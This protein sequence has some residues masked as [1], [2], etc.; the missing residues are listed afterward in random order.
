[1]A[2]IRIFTTTLFQTILS[3][4]RDAAEL[5]H[6]FAA[7]FTT[8]IRPIGSWDN[9]SPA[10][11]AFQE[12]SAGRRAQERSSS[13]PLGRARDAASDRG[14]SHVDNTNFATD[15]SRRVALPRP[16]SWPFACR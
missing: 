16:R 5:L 3:Y 15:G 10:V 4:V 1:M 11:L 9:R 6:D 7:Q 12:R 14:D 13:R 2:V 8:V